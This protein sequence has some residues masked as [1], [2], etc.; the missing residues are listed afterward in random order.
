MTAVAPGRNVAP[1]SDVPGEQ[2]TSEGGSREGTT[3]PRK[4]A[5]WPLLLGTAALVLALDQLT[6]WWAVEVLD[7]RTIELVGSLR[8]SVTVNYGSAFSL[9]NGRGP[10]ISLL[11][12]AIVAVLLRSGRNA[13][14]VPLAVA[15]GLVLGGAVGNLVDRAF[16]PG[17]GFLGGGVVDFVD[18]QWW[19]VFNLADAAIVV[20][21]VLLFLAQWREDGA[22]AGKPA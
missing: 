14:T 6:K 20:G 4:G 13:R 10:L 9:A 3:A 1:V 2:L 22:E 21:A 7:T 18:L 12:L 11:A 19:P 16:R 17:D 8:L 15:I 5:R